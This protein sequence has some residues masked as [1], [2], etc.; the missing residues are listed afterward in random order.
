MLFKS[1]G[2]RKR[3]KRDVNSTLMLTSLVD[4]FSIIVIF[5]IV[6]ASNSAPYEPNDKI[7]LPTVVE[8]GTA[9][10]ANKISISKSGYLYNDKEL[11]F[12]QLRAQVLADR[13]K[14]KN[15]QAIVEADRA[16]TYERIEPIMKL[17]ADLEIETIQLAVDA[18]ARQ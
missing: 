10:D 3:Q 16:A 13:S 4:A 12:D 8:A 17:M 1:K 14:F 7:A 15:H 18:E 6:V 2:F 11:T 9:L 5:L